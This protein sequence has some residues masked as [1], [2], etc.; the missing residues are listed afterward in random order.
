[1]DKLDISKLQRDDDFIKKLL[2]YKDTFISIEAD[3]YVLFPERFEKKEL[4]ILS[5]TCQVTGILAIVV[6]NKYGITKIPNLVEMLPDEIDRVEVEDDVYYKFT[7]NK[8][9]VLINNTNIVKKSDKAYDFFELLMI[10]GKIP[11]YINYIDMV[12]IFLNLEKYTGLK[13]IKNSTVVEALTAIIT[14][15]KGNNELD[16]RQAI[17]KDSDLNKVIPDYVGLSNIY[18][19]FKSTPNKLL[20]NFFT[21]A[22]NSSILYPEEDMS[23]L[24]KSLRE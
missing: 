5:N 3:A 16:Y 24:E 20:G 22:V 6:G 23:D 4:A 9:D 12:E 17:N 18:Y 14:K 11:W 2:K 13:A 7:F 19:S 8:G 1:M 15:V 10:Q 21:K